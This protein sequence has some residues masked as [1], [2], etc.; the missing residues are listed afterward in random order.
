MGEIYRGQQRTILSKI[1]GW[2]SVHAYVPPI[3]EVFIIINVHSAPTVLF[4]GSSSSEGSLFYFQAKCVPNDDMTKKGS[5]GIFAGEKRN[6]GLKRSF[7]K[8]FSKFFF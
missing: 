7:G 3:F 6:V 4:A 1:S 5:S 8:F 2:G